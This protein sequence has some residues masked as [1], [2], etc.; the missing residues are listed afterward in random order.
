MITRKTL[1][2]SMLLCLVAGSLT[3]VMELS[4]TASIEPNPS[5]QDMLQPPQ[6]TMPDM[7]KMHERMMA[8]MMA[9]MK[10]GDARLDALVTDVNTATGD[11]KINAVAAVVNE[12]VRQHKSMHMRMAEMHQQ[13]MGG[14]GMMMKK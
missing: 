14:R 2:I 12:L 3:G 6:P 5:A 13:M 7:M 9:E 11:G 4:A 8:E 10:A 1:A